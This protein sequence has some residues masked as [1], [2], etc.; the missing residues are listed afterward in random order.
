MATVHLLRRSRSDTTVLLLYCLSG[1]V[2]LGYQVAW[3]GICVERFGSTNLTFALV[4]C[5]FIAGL[6]TGALASRHVA[7]RIGGWLRT[8]DRLRIYGAVE[9]LVTAS[10]LLTIASGHVPAD[11]WGT[12]PY[13]SSGGIFEPTAAYQW[14]K[15][16]LATVCIFVPCFFMG[17]TFP[18]IC[19]AFGGQKA[20][21]RFPATLY[22][23]NTLGACLGVLVCQFI[24]L[25]RAGHG[26]TLWLMAGFN[27][28]IG[29]IFF[30]A[31]GD[32]SAVAVQD[33][34]ADAGEW[35]KSA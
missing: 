7:W 20:G 15:L 11:V 1:F 23:W 5:N 34:G 17:V 12:F 27:L 16:A 35:R 19:D 8:S 29:A 9:L 28:V 10:I 14:S 26:G 31:G 25:P 2:S 4:L 32:P 33:R 24:L 6:G 21:S 13:R 30:V 3:F 22:G 18:L